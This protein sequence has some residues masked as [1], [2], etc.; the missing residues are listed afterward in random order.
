MNIKLIGAVAGGFIFGVAVGTILMKEKY[1]K[2]SET[3]IETIREYYKGQKKTEK[4][5]KD[6]VRKVEEPVNDISVKKNSEYV[7]YTKY[8][9]KTYKEEVKEYADIP[10]AENPIKPYV[11]TEEMYDNENP[12]YSKEEMYFYSMNNVLTDIDDD[13]IVDQESLVGPDLFKRFESQ[14]GY[15]T[16]ID[17]IFIRNDNLARD[18]HILHEVGKFVSDF[19]D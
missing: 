9:K 16:F 1:R 18:F 6:E 5:V 17:E 8:S 12:Q 10:P 3:A 4:E 2:E 7:D 19:E 15:D 14:G 13:V 11:I